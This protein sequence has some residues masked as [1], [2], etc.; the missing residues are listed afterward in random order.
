LLHARD[1]TGGAQGTTA[2]FWPGAGLTVPIRAFRAF[3]ELGVL[4]GMDT[5]KGYDS[6]L[7][8]VAIGFLI[9]H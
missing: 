3:G 6:I 1:D 2:F 8:A 4:G 7:P 5:S 9:G